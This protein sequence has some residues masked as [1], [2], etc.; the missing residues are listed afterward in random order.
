MLKTE[1]YTKQHTSARKELLGHDC[2]VWR[3]RHERFARHWVAIGW[4][5]PQT[6]PVGNV[7][8]KQAHQVP[9]A[10]LSLRPRDRFFDSESRNFQRSLADF[11]DQF[12]LLHRISW[13]TLR[14]YKGL[15]KVLVCLRVCC[16]HS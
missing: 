15:E 14:E 12:N 6:P 5:A 9:S 11:I 10:Y 4:R 1:A 13:Q 16:A 7:D 3:N 2:F 8:F